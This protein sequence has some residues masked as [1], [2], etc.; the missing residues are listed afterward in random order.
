MRFAI[1]LSIL[2][3]ALVTGAMSGP[4]TAADKKPARACFRADDIRTW[5]FYNHQQ[6]INLTTNR[7]DVFTAEVIGICP[8][9]DFAQTLGIRSRLSSFICE[10]D[11]ADLFVHDASGPQRC[12]MQKIHKLSAD[13][14]AALPKEQKP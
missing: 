11:D 4:A 5:K 2:A 8:S 7:K 1:P 9:A 14:V 13:E 10:G 3:A 6:H 12:Q